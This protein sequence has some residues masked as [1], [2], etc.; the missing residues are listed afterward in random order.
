MWK[1]LISD[2]LNENHI[3]VQATGGVSQL[4]AYFLDTGLFS[5][6]DQGGDQTGHV[7]RMKSGMISPPRRTANQLFS[8]GVITMY[9]LKFVSSILYVSKTLSNQREY[10][11]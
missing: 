4:P 9:L 1:L 6:A 7:M 3:E 10:G 5:F 11:N 2:L 8:P